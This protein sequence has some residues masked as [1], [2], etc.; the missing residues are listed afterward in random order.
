MLTSFVSREIQENTMKSSLSQI[1]IWLQPQEILLDIDVT[2][3]L[4]VL[5]TLAVGHRKKA[6][7]G[8]GSDRSGTVEA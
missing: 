2:T 8:F 3:Q 7:L 4:Q 5:E 1:A 6:R